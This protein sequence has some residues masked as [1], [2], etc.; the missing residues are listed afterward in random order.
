MTYLPPF[1]K[2]KTLVTIS[3]EKGKLIVNSSYEEFL[4]L[5]RKVLAVIEVD[6]NW[7]L[8]QYPDVVEGIKNGKVSSA[9]DHFVHNGY[10]EGRLPFPIEVDERWYLTENPLVAEFVRS[11][12]LESAQQHFE[13]D[14]YKEGRLPFPL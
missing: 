10:F 5:I 11:G 4:G 12:R 13:S 6:E 14:G 1:D 7:Y 9:Q 3:N 8:T 2:L